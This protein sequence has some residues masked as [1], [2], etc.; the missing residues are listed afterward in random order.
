MKINEKTKK[1]ESGFAVELFYW[2]QALAVCLVVLVLIN[3]FFF[4]MS[5]VVGS[6]MVPTLHESERVIL[7]VFG[8][9]EPKRGDIVV[10]SAPNFDDDPLVK[11]IIAVGGDEI[12]IDDATGQVTVN[13]EIQYEPYI[14]EMI[15]DNGDWDYPVTVPDGFV[16]FMGDN[17]NGSSDSRNSEIGMQP[18]SNIIGKVIFRIWPLKSIGAVK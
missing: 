12:S 9:N 2:A 15:R 16:F 7:R 1:A 11:R 3:T 6:S 8:Y 10:V 13:G 14:K 18:V 5:G 4:R 17:R